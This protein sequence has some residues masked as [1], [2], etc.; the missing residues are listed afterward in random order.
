M[1][2][3]ETP[4]TP[5]SIDVEVRRSPRFW[6]FIGAGAA[7][8]ILAALISAYS[9]EPHA[10][11]TRGAVAGF[12]MVFFGLAGVFLAALAYLLVDKVMLKKS[13]TMRAEEIQGRDVTDPDPEA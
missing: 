4:A 7:V 2:S 5:S 3:H 8:G 6:P 13:R 10:E 11:F 9:G 1:D 12:L